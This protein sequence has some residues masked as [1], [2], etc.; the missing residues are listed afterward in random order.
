MSERD[1][2]SSQNSARSERTIR[3]QTN[4][5]SQLRERVRHLEKQLDLERKE[6]RTLE[7]RAER[8][9][10]EFKQQLKYSK[11]AAR[12]HERTADK[13]KEKLRKEYERQSSL[14]T[15]GQELLRQHRVSSSPASAT[16]TA[17]RTPSSSKQK[18]RDI[19]ASFLGTSILQVRSRSNPEHQHTSRTQVLRCPREVRDR[20]A[21]RC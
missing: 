8:T 6:R 13:L 12:V 17:M 19:H 16:N 5:T 1:L 3:Q 11:H 20:E 14:K 18:M 7:K 2:A 4:L 10:R 21:E 15:R 9:K